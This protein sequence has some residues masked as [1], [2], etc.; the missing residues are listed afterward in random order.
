MI[1]DGKYKNDVL[2]NKNNKKELIMEVLK[3]E[4]KMSERFDEFFD[5]CS[6]DIGCVHCDFTF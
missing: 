4:T 6:L 3:I 2:T 5:M 1:Q